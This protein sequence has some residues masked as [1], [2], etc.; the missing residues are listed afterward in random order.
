[1]DDILVPFRVKNK[2]SSLETFVGINFHIGIFRDTLIINNSSLIHI[3][4]H[5]HMHARIYINLYS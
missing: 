4:T 5:T 2:I 3:H 1:M